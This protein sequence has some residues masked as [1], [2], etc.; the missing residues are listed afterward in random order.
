MAVVANLTS[1]TIHKDVVSIRT[2]DDALRAD[3]A[4]KNLLRRDFRSITRR[5]D[6][7]ASTIVA[8]RRPT[9]NLALAETDLVPS[10]PSA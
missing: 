9:M 5:P 10:E 2:E 8:C 6:R 1:E 7:A 3:A 4:V